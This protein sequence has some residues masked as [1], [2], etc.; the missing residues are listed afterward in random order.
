MRRAVFLAVTL[1]LGSVA[2]AR[3][4]D[5][6]KIGVLYSYT[7]STA[8][9]G[10]TF[11][12]ALNLFTKEHG[13]TIAGRKVVLIRRDDTGIAPDT[14]KRL[15]QELIVQEHVDLLLGLTFTPNAIAVAGLSTQARKP[16][17]IVNAATS[18]I[19]AKA[20]YAVRFGFTTAQT[21][22]PLAQWAAKS[23]K[24][25]AYTMFQDY[26]PGIDAGAAFAQAFTA[27]GGNVLGEVRIPIANADF[28]AYVQRVKD[29]K[30]DVMYVFLNAGGAA[31]A[32]LKACKDAGFDR[33][34]ITVLASGDVVAENAL[35]GLGDVA[36]G[37]VTTMNYSAWHPSALNRAFVKGF[38]TFEPALLPDFGAVA[39]YDALN[40]AYRAIA[41]QNGAV[42]PDRTIELVRGM[43]F[44]SPRGPIRVDPETRDLV[45][46][47]YIRK[48]QR[49]QGR[50][51]NV[52]FATIPMV[53]DPNEAA[54]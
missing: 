19:I 42:D 15:A 48:T 20:P 54:H 13:D 43:A 50:L 27:A 2:G 16:L 12:A 45:Q 44:E 41:A 53:K 22:V 51:E 25:T 49:R 5:P 11:D 6:I 46:N 9:A 39:A 37:L 1:L 14:A 10:R 26:G 18:G 38:Q 4:A 40:A 29:A 7:G 52:E 31:Q 30:P 17:F 35:P 21:T 3:A 34:G 36:D 32:L 47:V 8:T 23:G 28:T 24:K 33:L